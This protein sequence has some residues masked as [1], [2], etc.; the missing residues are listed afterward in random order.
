M[1]V[2]KNKFVLIYFIIIFFPGITIA[3]SDL[4]KEAIIQF[5]HQKVLHSVADLG[6][7]IK[8]CTEQKKSVLLD[9]KTLEKINA[10]RDEL[11]SSLLHLSNQNDEKCEQN[12]RLK[13]AYDLGVL[14][15]FYRYFSIDVETIDGV[16]SE[17]IFPSMAEIELSIKYSSYPEKL[18]LYLEKTIGDQP[19]DLIKT[20]GIS[21][22]STTY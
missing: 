19:F 7:K 17:L 12:S 21:G 22:L 10:K 14:K 15:T 6:E 20:M 1:R 5:L 8:F 3:D 11:L 16:N 9:K 4:K 2:S 18:K 13:L